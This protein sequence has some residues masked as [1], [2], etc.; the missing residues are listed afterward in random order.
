[1]TQAQNEAI[2]EK[3]TYTLGGLEPREVQFLVD[4]IAT[5]SQ[6]MVVTQPIYAK[7]TGQIQAQD[8]ARE[9]AKNQKKNAPSGADQ[10]AATKPPASQQP[11]KPNAARRSKTK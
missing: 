2:P 11:P 3:I 7:I 4:M 8:Q 9:A 6:P 1:M 5:V 10:P